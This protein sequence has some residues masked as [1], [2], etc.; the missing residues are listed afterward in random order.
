MTTFPSS[1]SVTIWKAE[2]PW[3]SE[4][5]ESSRSECPEGRGLIAVILELCASLLAKV[6]LL[7]Y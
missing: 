6:G 4:M 1:F 5:V 3:W 7:Q 2:S